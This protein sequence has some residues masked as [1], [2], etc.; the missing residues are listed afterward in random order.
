MD[1]S[2]KIDISDSRVVYTP[3]CV[4]RIG[5]LK[6]GAGTCQ[7]GS[8][9]SGTCLTYGH[10]AGDGCYGDGNSARGPGTRSCVSNGNGVIKPY[11]PQDN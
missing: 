1:A 5:D 6:Q 9:D 2:K 3:P 4:V 10:S 7:S 8:G 11:C